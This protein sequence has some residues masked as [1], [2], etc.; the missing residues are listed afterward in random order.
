MCLS[1]KCS[2]ACC[3]KTQLRWH[4]QNTT[5]IEPSRNDFLL[6]THRSCCPSSCN[7][8]P[9]EPMQRRSQ[10]RCKKKHTCKVYREPIFI[11]ASP[12]KKS[13]PAPNL[14]VGGG[15]SP[16]HP[17]KYAQVKLDPISPFSGSKIK[18][19]SNHDLTLYFQKKLS[20]ELEL[21]SI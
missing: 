14:M 10:V 16:T 20:K 4:V 8:Q 11:F 18:N 5:A 2:P 17:E 9:M 3:H 19:T 15:F 6:M 7:Q 12:K 21:L 13:S 1:S